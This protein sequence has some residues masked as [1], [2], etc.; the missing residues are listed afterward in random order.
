[1]ARKTEGEI[2]LLT[3]E[4]RSLVKSGEIL[5]YSEQDLEKKLKWTRKSIR[6]HLKEIKQEIGTRDIKVI[7]LNLMNILEEIMQ[8]LEKYWRKA[9]EEEDERKIMYYM[10]QMFFAIEKFT[11]FL[12]RFG[13]KQKV[14]DK[15]DLQ[16][17]I[18]H[19]QF[20]IQIIDDRRQISNENPND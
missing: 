11:D 7:S 19:K 14:A 16:A 2:V 15:I 6:K 8:D 5:R 18:T 17:D 4:L 10:K 20:T 3:E 9:K 12:E 1:M 13:I